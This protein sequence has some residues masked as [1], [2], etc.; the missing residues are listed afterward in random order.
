MPDTRI[1]LFALCWDIFY[2]KLKKHLP[3]GHAWLE[4]VNYVGLKY[5]SNFDQSH[6]YNHFNMPST[7]PSE[8][9]ARPAEKFVNQPPIYVQ[10]EIFHPALFMM[11]FCH[12]FMTLVCLCGKVLVD[13]D[14]RIS[15]EHQCGAHF[16][17]NLI[18]SLYQS[19]ILLKE[20]TKHCHA[21]NKQ[22]QIQTRFMI[23]KI[24]C[25]SFANR[26]LGMAPV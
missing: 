19:Q 8:G 3:L 25:S 21:D 2:V 10:W 16:A 5:V 11:S 26:I 4:D 18:T 12:W 17:R 14:L 22:N 1:V 9:C 15:F 13:L 7:R 23:L 6:C 20:K 24:R